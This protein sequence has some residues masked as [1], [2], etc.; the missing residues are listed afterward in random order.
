MSKQ[1]RPSH[2]KPALESS[3]KRLNELY[4]NY[5]DWPFLVGHRSA[6]NGFLHPFLSKSPSVQPVAAYP[7]ET[8]HSA[9]GSEQVARV[10]QG[11]LPAL[12]SLLDNLGE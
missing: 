6:T 8:F 1:I 11:K 10:L 7:K 12:I 4:C 2:R 3:I 5:H 9:T